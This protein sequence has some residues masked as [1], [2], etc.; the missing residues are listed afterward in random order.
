MNKNTASACLHAVMTV[1]EQVAGKINFIT[2]D[3]TVK[4][5]HITIIYR[6]D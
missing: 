1:I 2:E 6:N 5:T 4:H 3:T